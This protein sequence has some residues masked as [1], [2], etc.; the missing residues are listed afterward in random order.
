[1]KIPPKP[2]NEQQRLQALQDYHVLD[3]LPE[4]ELDDLTRIASHI[5]KTPIALISLIDEN[6]QWFK[7]RVGLDATETPRDVAFCA[8]AILGDEVFVVPDS[9]K[10]GR[11]H[12]NPLATGAPH[13]RFYAGAPL[14][15]P[16]GQRIGTL[17]VIDHV[18]RDLTPEEL[19]ALQALARQAVSQLELRKKTASILLAARLMENSP[20]AMFC[21]DYQSGKGVFVDWNKAAEEYWGLNKLAVVGKTDFDFFPSDQAEA[22]RKKDLE[23]ISS[24]APAF[25]EREPI[26]SKARG[27]RWVRTWKVPVADHDGKPRYLLGISLDMT[28]QF[29][30]ETEI[31]KAKQEAEKI[32]N[33]LENAEI[34]G[35]FGSWELDLKTMEGRWSKG[36]N[37]LFDYEEDPKRP[38][39]FQTFLEL[40]FP[41]DRHK[42]Q[43]VVKEI[44]ENGRR[45][46][47]IDYRIRTKAGTI[48][49]IK[50]YGRVTV[51]EQGAPARILGTVQD[52]TEIQQLH[53]SLVASREEAISAS[54]AKSTFLA[55][56]SH[57][58]RT[59]MNGIIGMSSL[60]LSSATDGEQIEQLQIIQS[61]GNTLLQLID[62]IL[63]FSK[64]EANKLQLEQL[65]FD[66]DST[67][68]EV[69]KLFG[70]KAQEKGLSLTYQPGIQPLGWVLGDATR[71]KQILSNLVANAIKFTANGSV[72]VHSRATVEKDSGMRIEVSVKDTGI[73]IPENLR[74]KLFQSFSQIDAS[75]TRKFG[76][77]GLGLAISKGLCEKMGGGISVE[78]QP[79]AGSTFTFHFKAALADGPRK[80]QREESTK[81][82]KLGQDHPL[83]ILVAEDNKTNQMVA[84]GLL[85]E[86]GYTAELAEDG[87]EVLQRLSSATYDLILMDC[88]MPE[89]DGFEAMRQ[90]LARYGNADRPRVVAL[91]AST[92][93][94]DID[95]CIESGMDGFIAKP[96]RPAALST[97]LKA[98]PRRPERKKSAA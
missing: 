18:P 11:F 37:M 26:D 80:S 60:L 94:E 19:A 21:K 25:I 58:I 83:R 92:M 97:E 24:G 3:T 9:S 64:L 67:V 66:F 59:P 62:E 27:S 96:V 51:D 48:R 57:E 7:S 49:Y 73:G 34:T 79:G 75:T 71:L 88:H 14:R 23:V 39:N 45:H 10:D 2:G 1:V 84:L 78:S 77:T 72:E 53:D 16:T 56:M 31:M 8:H 12:D 86:L 85:K 43:S 38:P 63:D 95:R 47:D 28:K 82:R 54:Q 61:C 50:G 33:R 90:I 15:T 44:F 20:A 70:P 87:S 93:K 89:M 74:S 65:P 98:C 13:V 35:K 46:L 5:C 22:F 81:S 41:E 68:N 36:H 40:I 69:A 55:N 42:P 32:A 30:L 91:T 76:G 4:Q 17:C 6:R 29:E 52:I